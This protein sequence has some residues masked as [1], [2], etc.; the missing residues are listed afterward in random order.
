[1]VIIPIFLTN[2][3]T[4]KK[5][6]NKTWEKIFLKVSNLGGSRRGDPIKVFISTTLHYD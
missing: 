6:I 1:M 4:G 3:K 2:N 5:K